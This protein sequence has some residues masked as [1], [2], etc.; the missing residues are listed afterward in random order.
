MKMTTMMMVSSVL[1]FCREAD[2]SGGDG[3]GYDH[4]DLDD[5][6]GDDHRCIMI[7]MITS[8]LAATVGRQLV[9][10]RMMRGS[11]ALTWKFTFT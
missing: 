8:L 6:D 11:T 10:R 7:T 4:D 9:L 1:L 5:I 2:D 3:D